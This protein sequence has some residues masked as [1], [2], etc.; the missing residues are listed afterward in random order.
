MRRT[1]RLGLWLLA[2]LSADVGSVVAADWTGWRGP[3]R[4]G[5]VTDVPAPAT[6]PEKLTPLRSIEVG[7]GHSAPVVAGENVYVFSRQGDE[8]VA[9][10]YDLANGRQIWLQKYPAP[11]EMHPA[12]R[13]H[14]KGP[15]ATPALHDGKLVT[16]GVSGILTCWNAATGERNWQHE[17]TGLFPKTSPLYGASCS[18]LIVDDLVIVHVGGH[19]QGA[20]RAFRLATGEMKW[21][22]AGDGPGYTSAIVT[23]LGGVRQIVT[24]SQK[25]CL[26]LDPASGAL[27]WSLPFTTPFD[28]NSVTPVVAGDL[29]I[30]SGTQKATF[31]VRVQSREGK[32]QP[33]EVWQTKETAMYMSSPVL[34]E[35][36]LYGLTN[37]Q[38]GAYFCQEAATGKVLWTSPGRQGENA[39]L[40][41]AG[42]SLV[43][44]N[45]AGELL[46]FEASPAGFSVTRRYALGA[47]WTWAAPVL[48]GQRLLIKDRTKLTAYSIAAP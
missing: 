41:A 24:Q 40:L 48:V 3:L 19:N 6:W 36:R 33:E 25:L 11:Y 4:D 29:V 47:D 38:S 28:Q 2:I 26:A 34:V 21:D 46:V 9:A 10:C 18:P 8:E 7:E 39:M 37:R 30:F 16:F 32:L 12:A 22:W 15:R 44:L 23:T 35:G 5:I 14:G 1:L 42:N 13:K 31:A 27:L 45:T 43:S 20:L 17:F